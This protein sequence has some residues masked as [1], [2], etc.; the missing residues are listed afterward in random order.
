MKRIGRY[1]IR[2]RTKGLIVKLDPL[3]DIEITCYVDADFA[4]LWGVEDP[5]DPACVR[6]RTGYVFMVSGI[7]VIWGS[8]MQTEIAVSTMHAEYIALSTVMRE[9]LPFRSLLSEAL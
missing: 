7:P 1:L 9:L 5:Q 4:G 3:R 8:K 6:S 2:T